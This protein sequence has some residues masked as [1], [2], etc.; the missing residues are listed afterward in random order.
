MTTLI[1]DVAEVEIPSWVTDLDSFCR[2]LGQPN[3]PEKIPVWWLRGKVWVNMSREQLF[4]HNRVRTAITASLWELAEKN[5][6]G[7]LW[8]D[9][10]FLVSTL[11]NI[12]GNPDAL[13]ASHESLTT[14]E[15]S[16]TEG[17][18]DGFLEIHGTPEMVLEV[19]S[20]SSVKKD[21]KVLFEGYWEAG[22]AEYWLVDARKPPLRFDIWRHTDEGYVA[23]RKRDGWAKSS[24]FG[25]SFRLIA[26][27]DRSGLPTYR[28]ESR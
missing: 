12:A 11:G 13:F 14:G 1:N 28:L 24:V 19:I 5:E 27:T 16:L 8:G 26:S 2:W 22:I 15:V 9:G 7:V 20:R 6:L 4:S 3:F 17:T 23:A 21:T 25:K 10:A 18:D